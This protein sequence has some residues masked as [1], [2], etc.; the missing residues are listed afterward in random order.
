MK[1]VNEILSVSIVGCGWYGWPLAHRL[2]SLGWKVKGSKS[3]KAGVD[4]LCGSGIEGYLLDLDPQP[5][6]DVQQALFDADVLVVNVPPRR[7]P[8]LG[9]YHLEQMR[10][11][12]GLM[13][14]SRIEKVLFI[15]ST[16]VYP[17]VNRIVTEHEH[18]S[19]DKPAGKVLKRVEGFWRGN[20][21]L[22][23]TIVRFAGL[24]GEGRDPGRFLAGK[25]D[26]KNANA[27]VNLIHLDDCLAITIEILKQD[28]WG[29]TLNACCPGHPTRRDF[30]QAAAG[31][32]ALVAPTFSDE[33]TTAFKQVDSSLLTHL[34]EYRFQHPDPMDFP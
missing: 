33:P 18:L 11:L 10:A 31:K 8:D 6:A 4:A 21:R 1:P 5:K 29:E 28:L 2:K 13:A 23:T 26:V 34:L 20:P 32:A 9:R 30:Y 24:V 15:S 17:N 19:P 16:S 22:R 12:S 27:P 25:R 3:S 7:R 14:G